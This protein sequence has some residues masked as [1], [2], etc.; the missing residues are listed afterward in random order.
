MVTTTSNTRNS[1]NPTNDGSSAATSGSAAGSASGAPTPSNSPC[2]NATRSKK[3]KK[4]LTGKDVAEKLR[5]RDGKLTSLADHLES[6]PL[7]I[8]TVIE[9]H[10]TSM[11]DLAL[12]IG[13]KSTPLARFGSTLKLKNGQEVQY[14]AGCCRSVKNPTTGSHRIKDTDDFKQIVS[15]YDS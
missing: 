14:T 6:Q 4:E 7:Q 2:S 1:A 9:Q 13:I 10:T 11:L 5:K 15:E 3:K 8:A 12:E